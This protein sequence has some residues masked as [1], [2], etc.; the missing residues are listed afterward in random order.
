MFFHHITDVFSLSK[1]CFHCLI[2]SLLCHL[3]RQTR[4]P[5]HDGSAGF[6]PRQYDH[7]HW[8]QAMATN[9]SV[10]VSRT[11]GLQAYLTKHSKR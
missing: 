2:S 4:P 8:L 9:H 7:A 10:K 11:Y 6:L 1:L 5:V 3:P